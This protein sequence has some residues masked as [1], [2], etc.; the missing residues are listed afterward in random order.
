MNSGSDGASISTV[1][2]TIR[3]FFLSKPGGNTVYEFDEAGEYCYSYAHLDHYAQGLHEGMRMKRGDIIAYVGTTGNADPRTPH[4]HFAVFE[5]GP[6][7]E[8]WKGKPI[9]P[10]PNLVGALKKSK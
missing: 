7:R 9:N 4:L 8:W 5:L 1:S 3:K 2:G 6:K 10:Y